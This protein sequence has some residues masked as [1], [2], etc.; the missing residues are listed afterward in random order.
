M[1]ISASTEC[2]KK[3]IAASN[4][5][6]LVTETSVARSVEF[7]ARLICKGK[8]NVRMDSSL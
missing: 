8:C 4:V 3:R 6:L 2:A 5:V 1:S 7:K